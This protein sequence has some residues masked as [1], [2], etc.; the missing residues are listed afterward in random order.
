MTVPVQFTQTSLTTPLAEETNVP[1]RPAFVVRVLPEAGKGLALNGGELTQKA[2]PVEEALV[3]T[4]GYVLPSVATLYQS[5]E[6]TE[7]PIG[8][9]V[10]LH[11]ELQSS[12]FLGHTPTE[13]V[14]FDLVFTP[15]QD[16]E[17]LV[18]YAFTYKTTL[19]GLWLP[20]DLLTY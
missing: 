4:L 13:P 5:D 12:G 1:L 16:L 9:P 3:D 18:R 14:Y 8:N 11:V 15:E 7:L 20:S 10:L 17:P 2:R 6:V 19:P